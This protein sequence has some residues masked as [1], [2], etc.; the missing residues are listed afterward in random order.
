MNK[1]NKMKI[2][3]SSFCILY[4][5]FAFIAGLVFLINSKEQIFLMYYIL[6]FTL[7]F[8]DSFHLVPRIIRNIKGNSNKVEWW[9]NL[10]LIITSITMTVFYIILFYIWKIKYAKDVLLLIDTIIWI[11]SIV[12]IVLCLLPQNNWFNG[13]N[14]KMALYRNIVFLLIGI[15]ETILFITLEESFG[16]A[17]AISILLS[18]AFYMPVALFS[19]E[20]PKLGM[21]MIPKTIMYIIIIS[22]GLSLI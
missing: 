22:L 5:L 9:M 1:K 4:L 15:I 3:E 8:G 21:L 20:K 12:R 19:K 16:I 14:K 6:T 10:G 18:F 11:I 13:G 17:M 7:C 2:F